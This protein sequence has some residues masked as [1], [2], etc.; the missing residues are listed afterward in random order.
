[1]MEYDINQ[2]VLLTDPVSGKTV[3]GR[4]YERK[5]S[6]IPPYERVYGVRFDEAQWFRDFCTTEL[7][8]LGNAL[9]VNPQ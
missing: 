7:H 9:E 2:R 8:V 3:E 5:W 4:V 6:E 1:M